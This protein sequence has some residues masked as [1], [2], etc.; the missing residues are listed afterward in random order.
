MAVLKEIDTAKKLLK[1]LNEQIGEKDGE[2][3][4][5]GAD[6]HPDFDSFLAG[7]KRADMQDVL[8]QACTGALPKHI[9]LSEKARA[10][11]ESWVPQWLRFERSEA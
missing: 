1:E 2:L 3:A 8:H 6:I 9:E 5:L 11:A 4:A 10:A 7:R